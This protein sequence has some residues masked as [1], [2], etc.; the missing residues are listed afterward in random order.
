MRHWGSNAR[1]LMAGRAS[2]DALDGAG[3]VLT[4]WQASEQAGDGLDD[5]RAACRQ[6]GGIM[7]LG[8]GS[9]VWRTLQQPHGAKIGTIAGQ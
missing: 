7:L 3:K 6:W 2:G 8:D 4:T 1:H 9:G 5:L